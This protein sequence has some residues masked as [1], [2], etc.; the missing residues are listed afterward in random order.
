MAA[1][2]PA[3]AASGQPAPARALRL[4]WALSEAQPRPSWLAPSIAAL[5]ALQAQHPGGCDIGFAPPRAP[6]PASD[7]APFEL[8][9]HPGAAPSAL[10]A[11]PAPGAP[12]RWWLT[13]RHGRE[14]DPERPL[15]DDI[16]AGRGIGLALWAPHPSGR[17]WVCLRQLHIDAD[18]HYAQGRQRLAG[19]IARMLWHAGLDLLLGVLPS[20]HVYPSPRATGLAASRRPPRQQHPVALLLR[21]RWRSW[22]ARQRARWFREQWRLGIVDLPLAA[23]ASQP[24]VPKPRWL[25]PYPGLGYWADPAA[26]AGS[27]SRVLVEYFDERSGIGRIEQLRFSPSQ[28]GVADRQVMTLGDGKHASFPLAVQLEGRWFGLAETAAQRSCVLHEIDAS[29]QW[30][31]LAT[32]LPGMAAADPALFL[33][34]GRYWLACTDVDLGAMDNLCLFHADQPEGPWL[35]HANNPVKTD[36]SGARMAGAF[37]WHQG[38]LYRPAQNCLG[39]YGAGVALQ[40]VLRCSPTEFEE[41]P[42]RQLSP[43]PTGPC[44]HGLH[45]VNAW[46]TRTLVD[47]KRHVFSPTLGWLKLRRRLARKAPP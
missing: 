19:A 20:N 1:A 35:P 6:T 13:D 43:D 22:L 25:P 2:V 36:V 42:V 4:A 39:T 31:P 14:L 10:P 12:F 27:D 11:A 17:G 33:W 16:T 7:A 9:L 40:R 21:G 38:Q 34:Q 24:T 46:G 28:Y 5:A 41:E 47:G 29:G 37:F 26:A 30:Q 32:L 45:T 8:R 44:P 18:P 3:T 23:L 15:L